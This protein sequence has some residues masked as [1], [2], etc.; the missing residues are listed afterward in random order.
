MENKLQP[1]QWGFKTTEIV[2]LKL[3]IQSQI[4]FISVKCQG[5]I[6]ATELVRWVMSQFEAGGL[7]PRMSEAKLSYWVVSS[8]GGQENK[9]GLF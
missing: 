2:F 6:E 7:G 4:W 9:T 1:S 5:K 3:N 8:N